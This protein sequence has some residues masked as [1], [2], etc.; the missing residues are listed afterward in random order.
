MSLSQSDTRARGAPVR[1]SRATRRRPADLNGSLADGLPSPYHVF[2]R[3]AWSALREDTPMTLSDEEVL[4][5]RALGDPIELPEVETIYLPLSRLLN[6]YVTAT[7]HLH[8]ATRRFLAG[9]GRGRETRETFAK[10][11]YVIGVAGSVA[12]GKSTTAR[13]LKALLARWPSSPKVDLVT[14]DGFLKPNARLEAEGPDGAEGLPGELRPR[15]A[16][17]LHGRDQGWRGAGPRARLQPSRIRR[18]GRRAEHDRPARHPHPRGRQ[19][20]A[21]RRA[22]RRPHPL[23][24]RLFRLL[25]LY[26]CRRG[27]APALVCR[28]LHAAAWHGVS[29]PALLLPPVQPHLGRGGR[30]DGQPDLGRD[31][32]RQPPPEH[33]ADAPP[34]PTCCF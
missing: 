20:A 34:A 2:S 17:A 29:R 26:R 18:D 14:T 5:L 30:G 9:G 24:L 22:E 27:H 3:P 23:R 15:R 13:L 33:P 28:A 1:T 16:P 21:D 11:P 32:P 25:D 4:R 6:L 12:V 10:V 8:R 7:Q 19:R 31:Q